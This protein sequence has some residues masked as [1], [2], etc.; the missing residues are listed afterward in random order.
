MKQK[1]KPKNRETW[2]L[3]DMPKNVGK[4]VSKIDIPRR[5]KDRNGEKNGKIGDCWKLE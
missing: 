1:M 3:L 5:F 4:S 2:T